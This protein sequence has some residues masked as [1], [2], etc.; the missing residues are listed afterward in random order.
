MFRTTSAIG[1]VDGLGDALG[2]T[3]AVAVAVGVG[4][5]VGHASVV[6]A[7]WP[8]ISPLGKLTEWMFT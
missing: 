2:A 1:G 4:L 3:V 8:R 6:P 7:I 5:G